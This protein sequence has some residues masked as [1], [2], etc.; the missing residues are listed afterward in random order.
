MPET[1]KRKN[2]REEKNEEKENDRNDMEE[3]RYNAMDIT[4]AAA[5]ARIK[6]GTANGRRD[7]YFIRLTGTCS[8][9]RSDIENMDRILCG[10]EAQGR[11]VYRRISSFP[12]ITGQEDIGYYLRRYD[13]WKASGFRR[14]QTKTITEQEKETARRVSAACREICG[15][16]RSFH[17][18]VSEHMERNFAIKL[19][20]WMDTVGADFLSQRETGKKMKFAAENI[21]REQEY[22]FCYLMT[23]T[24]VDVLLLQYAA[25]IPASLAAL[26]LS[27]CRRL[28]EM[29][30]VSSLPG[31][32]PAVYR[33]QSGMHGRKA[34]KKATEQKTTAQD[35]KDGVRISIQQTR[36]EG[37]KNG[38]TQSGAQRLTSERREKDFEELALLA[39]SVVMIAV[40]DTGGNVIATGSGIMI[41]QN[42]YILTN[43]HVVAGGGVYY[44]VRIE[45]EEKTYETDEVVKYN[46][47]LDLAIIHIDRTLTPLPVYG[48]EKALVRGQKVVAIGSP[49][50]MFNS[51]SDGIISGF[52]DFDSVS[53]IQFTAPVS[54]GS[55]GGALLNLYGEVIGIITAGIDQG[56]NI[57]LAVGYEFIE[58]FTKG[59]R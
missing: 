57:N 19:L 23:K 47:V 53:M 28:G 31:C 22:L 33:E 54:H 34:Q 17:G 55:S 56:Q 24:G 26:N 45:N 18:N 20:F 50:G 13:E 30:G 41:G 58:I 21:V 32:D 11:C 14:L 3:L 15:I 46:G 7:I 16:Y 44:S 10:E 52:R 4:S 8:S 5:F 12:K 27:A 25:D 48:G 29:G 40:C 43:N 38:G 2:G 35:R 49:L 36:K 6:G 1:K 9:Y 39:S 37:P 42:G 59:F 51:V